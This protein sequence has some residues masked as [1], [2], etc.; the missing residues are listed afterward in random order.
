MLVSA[1]IF[2]VA[3]LAMIALREASLERPDPASTYMWYPVF[4][5]QIR[6][7]RLPVAALVPVVPENKDTL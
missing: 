4:M 1:L 3:L 6:G 5:P 2:Q 7:D